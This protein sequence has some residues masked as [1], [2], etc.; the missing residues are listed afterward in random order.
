MLIDHICIMKRTH[1]TI[2]AALAITL[3]LILMTVTSLSAQW[4]AS[5]ANDPEAKRILDKLKRDYDSYKSMEVA[6]TLTIDLPEQSSE[7]QEGKLGQKGDQFFVKL[8]D[9]HIFCNGKTVWLYLPSNNEVQINDADFDQDEASMSPQTM[10]RI[11]ESD[12]YYY[13]ITDQ[14]GNTVTIEF[15]P[16][17][18]ESE[19]SKMRLVVDKVKNQMKSLKIFAKDGSRYTLEM[20]KLTPNATFSSDAFTF[21]PSK[22]TGIYIEDLRID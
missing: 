4:N 12:Q 17:D 11:Y 3:G 16:N 5:T 9:Q 22:Y 21:D 18:S 6:F 14:S 1:Y 20:K 7:V 8:D 19:Y 15:K 2:T 13:A 10:M